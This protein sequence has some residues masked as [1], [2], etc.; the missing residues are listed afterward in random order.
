MRITKEILEYLNEAEDTFEEGK[1]VRELSRKNLEELKQRYYIENHPNTSYG[2]LVDI[3]DLVSDEEIFK[4]YEG[5]IFYNDDFF[6]NINEAEDTEDLKTKE[7]EEDTT[8]MSKE[9]IEDETEEDTEDIIED[10]VEEPFYATTKEFDELRDLLV[11]LDYRLFLINDSYVVVGRLNGDEVEFLVDKGTE[12]DH[13][14]SFE[15]AP[16][17]LEKALKLTTLY[18][19][20]DV[21][22][23]DD[24]IV[25]DHT[26]ILEFLNKE[27]GEDKKEESEEIEDAQEEEQEKEQHDEEEEKED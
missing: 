5:I 10:E 23:T 6:G 8:E 2:E 12:E 27:L 21:E 26:S 11:E 18:L 9:E 22:V 3:D 20:P 19:S 4:E 25:A 24:T 1:T 16:D 15:K 13:K 14:Y 17:T 7:P